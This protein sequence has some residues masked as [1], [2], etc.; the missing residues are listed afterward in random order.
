MHLDVH[1]LSM[2]NGAANSRVSPPRGHK[3]RGLDHTVL[4]FAARATQH[5]GTVRSS[6][7]HHQWPYSA[8]QKMCP[9]HRQHHQQQQQDKTVLPLLLQ[10]FRQREE[11]RRGERR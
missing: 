9:L 5:P 11:G 1:H 8:S 7:V 6:S 3:L 4:L 2:N 10:V